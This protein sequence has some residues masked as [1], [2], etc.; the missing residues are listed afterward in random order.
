MLKPIV[1]L[2]VAVASSSIASARDWGFSKDTVYEAGLEVGRVEDAVRLV[3]NRLDTLWIDSIQLDILR[4]GE[5]QLGIG[6]TWSPDTIA[7]YIPT[8][9]H[10]IRNT[11]P[12]LRL[13]P[14]PPGEFREL[15]QFYVQRCG[16]PVKRG[17]AAPSD[18]LEGRLRFYGRTGEEDT[19]TVFGSEFVP[20][21]LR[22]GFVP[23]AGKSDRH[24]ARR[25]ARGRRLG[26]RA[27]FGISR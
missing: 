8:S 13:P 7:L 1:F 5:S 24:S 14:V 9:F 22:S 4:S 10:L 23:S 26:V 21:G 2:L 12:Y 27:T 6:F 11:E 25:D 3:N 18:S 15:S 20:V 17:A 16:C 19:L